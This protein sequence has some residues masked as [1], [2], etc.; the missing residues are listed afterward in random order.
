MKTM[1]KGVIAACLLLTGVSAH[2]QTYELIE[3]KTGL[4]LSGAGRMS[5]MGN[6]LSEVQAYARLILRGLGC[7]LAN[8]TGRKTGQAQLLPCKIQRLYLDPV[9][10]GSPAGKALV[11]ALTKILAKGARVDLAG[12]LKDA[13][14]LFVDAT[15]YEVERRSV[16]EATR[17]ETEQAEAHRF[18]A[19]GRVGRVARYIAYVVET[20]CNDP[21]VELTYDVGSDQTEQRMEYAPRAELITYSSGSIYLLS[22]Q[23]HDGTDYCNVSTEIYSLTFTQKQVDLWSNSSGSPVSAIKRYGKKLREADSDMAY[24]IADVSYSPDF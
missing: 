10:D 8:P 4:S 12:S 21:E 24:G 1:I 15:E 23:K 13:Q 16:Q 3:V 7:P 19:A 6:D 11:R 9:G 20:D 5:L 22:A 17:N 14:A 2:G 18:A